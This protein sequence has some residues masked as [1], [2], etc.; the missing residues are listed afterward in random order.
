MLSFVQ[1]RTALHS[2]R[3]GESNV[4]L[5]SPCLWDFQILWTPPV[6][7]ASTADRP[8]G[9]TSDPLPICP[10]VL[11]VLTFLRQVL[12]PA[13]AAF[14]LV[15]GG[16]LLCM[17]FWLSVLLGERLLGVRNWRGEMGRARPHFHEQRQ[18][19]DDL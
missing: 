5:M 10:P 6:I 7:A 3:F 19:L 9:R 14:W 13:R 4:K 2:K 12:A 16:N 15:G 11:E 1:S 18:D 8:L 17:R